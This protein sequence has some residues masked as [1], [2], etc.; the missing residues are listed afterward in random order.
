M[1]VHA[2]ANIPTDTDT[3]TDLQSLDVV[4]CRDDPPLPPHAPV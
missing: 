1:A 4:A 3:L 2:A